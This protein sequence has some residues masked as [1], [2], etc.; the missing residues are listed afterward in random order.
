RQRA[1]Q[2]EIAGTLVKV[3]LRKKHLGARYSALGKDV[4]IEP[5]EA[6]LADGRKG[7]AKPQSVGRRVVAELPAS[8][9]DGAGRYEDDFASRRLEATDF[10]DDGAQAR[11]GY[12][13]LRVGKSA[14]S[15]LDDDPTGVPQPLALAL[16][17][18]E[19][20]SGVDDRCA[21]GSTQ[22]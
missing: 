1:P 7:L 18:A 20:M 16:A 12:A 3:L 17:H 4:L 21:A 13:A 9:P 11:Q 14:R 19:P 22:Q 10:L 2:I 8:Q 15:N 5:H 6:A